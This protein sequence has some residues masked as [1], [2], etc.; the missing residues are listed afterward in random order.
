MG[1]LLRTV[2]GIL[3]SGG[4]GRDGEPATSA[5]LYFP[6]SVAM[7]S[8]LRKLFI[9]DNWN[10]A[11]R[12]LNLATGTLTTVA[13][14]LGTYG[15]AG[16]G[17]RA[18][19]AQLHSPMGLAVD[20]YHRRVYIADASNHAI[21]RLA[22]SNDV[23]FVNFSFDTVAPDTMSPQPDVNLSNSSNATSALGTNRSLASAPVSS[24]HTKSPTDPTL[25]DTNSSNVSF[26]LI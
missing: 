26:T 25:N 10:H 4:H 16:N 18:T 14:T 6:F 17:G 1:G 5:Q 24:V 7:N 15:L 22:V 11:I 3:G 20:S 8:Q 21:R 2:A 13:G 23:R 9:A 19:W 12:L